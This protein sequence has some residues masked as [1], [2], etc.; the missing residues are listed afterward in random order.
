MKIGFSISN[1]SFLHHVWGSVAGDISLRAEQLGKFHT[2]S[3]SPPK[4]IVGEADEFIV[5]LAVRSQPADGNGHA[6]FK[7]AV[8]FC[9]RTV[10]GIKIVQELL[11]RRWEA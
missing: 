11:R 5:I 1:D 7:V 2:A 6:A 3:G 10:G 9:L 8:Q 4:R